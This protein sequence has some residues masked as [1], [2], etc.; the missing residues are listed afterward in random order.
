MVK[1]L[2]ILVVL[3]KSTVLLKLN[4]STCEVKNVVIQTFSDV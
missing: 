3:H 1:Y 4:Y 2:Y